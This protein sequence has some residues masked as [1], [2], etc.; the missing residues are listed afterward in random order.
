MFKIDTALGSYDNVNTDHS[1][2]SGSIA[3]MRMYDGA[4]T[5]AQVL[6]NYNEAV[7]HTGTVLIVK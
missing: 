7:P 6:N 2:F 4:L 1:G 5:D 3:I